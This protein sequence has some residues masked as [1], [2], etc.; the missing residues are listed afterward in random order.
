MSYEL[1]YNKY[2]KQVVSDLKDYLSRTK[3]SITYIDTLDLCHLIGCIE[4]L[5]DKLSNII[6]EIELLKTQEK[7]INFKIEDIE[8]INREEYSN[9]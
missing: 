1:I 9:E 3:E 4:H 2:T 5:E 7:L 6:R 8:R